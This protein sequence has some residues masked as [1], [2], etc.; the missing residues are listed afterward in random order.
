MNRR[1]IVEF[2]LKNLPILQTE[3]LII[4]SGS[5]GMRAAIEASQ[6][7]DV[8]LVTKGQLK[9]SNSR[10]AQGGIAV[11]MSQNDTVD[12]HVEDTL[13]AGNGLCNEKAVKIMVEEGI[14]RVSELIRWG[15][16]FDGDENNNLGFTIAAA[17]QRHRVVHRGDATGKETTKV[18]T[19]HLQKQK[20]I[21][22]I[23]DTWPLQL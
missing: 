2:N 1:Y 16:E 15:A 8:L 7:G 12:C 13:K 23:T 5:A 20:C 21:Q 18:L 3:F 9:E 22:C 11:A 6:H 14:D 19:N 10:Y 17:H 4:G